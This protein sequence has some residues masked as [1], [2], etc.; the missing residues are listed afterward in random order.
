M[1]AVIGGVACDPRL[2]DLASEEAYRLGIPLSEMMVLAL[3]SYLNAPPEL[4]KV[5][6]ASLGRPRKTSQPAASEAVAAE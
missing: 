1:R 6:R 5:P 2:K 4:A 3:V